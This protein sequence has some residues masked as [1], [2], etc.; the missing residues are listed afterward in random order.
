MPATTGTLQERA[1]KVLGTNQRAFAER[2]GVSRRTAQRWSDHGVPAYELSKLARLVYPHDPAMAA[3]A[4]AYAGTTVEALG[5]L[6]PPPPAPPLA[7][8]PPPLPPPPP[9]PPPDGVVDA[10]VCAASDAMDMMPRDVRAGLLA[11]F[12]RAREIGVSVEHV[13]KALRAQ[14]APLPAKPTESA[15]AGKRKTASA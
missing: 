6:P 7:P 11:A 2:M 1:Q 5:L 14:L 3:E 15:T 8:P 10:V 13:E 9:P 12:A 4:A